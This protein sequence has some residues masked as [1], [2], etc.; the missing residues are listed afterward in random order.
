MPPTSLLTFDVVML[1]RAELFWTVRPAISC[2]EPRD[3]TPLLDITAVEP[4]AQRSL[5]L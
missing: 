3:S 5:S 2:K 4:G 1:F